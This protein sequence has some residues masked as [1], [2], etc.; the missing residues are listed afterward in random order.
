M[1]KPVWLGADKNLTSEAQAL[2]LIKSQQFGTPKQ[3]S[4]R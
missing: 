1:E 2:H 4:S 3:D